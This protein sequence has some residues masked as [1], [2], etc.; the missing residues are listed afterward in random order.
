MAQNTE[1][2]WAEFQA[3][4]NLPVT[5]FSGIRWQW[6]VDSHIGQHMWFAIN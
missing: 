3:N 5:E 1:I 2:K 6:Q 4:R